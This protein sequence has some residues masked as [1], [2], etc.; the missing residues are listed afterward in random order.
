M[1]KLS[2][3]KA[4]RQYRS[5]PAAFFNGR[6]HLNSA[7]ESDLIHPDWSKYWTKY[8]YNLVE[9]GIL[10]ILHEQKKAERKLSVLDVGVGTGHWIE[11]YSSLF[12]IERMVG[13]DFCQPP[14][15]K[16]KEKKLDR[17]ISLLSWDISAKVP[18]RLQSMQFD[19]VNAIGV[20]FHIVDDAKWE[21]AIKNLFSLLKPEGILIVGGDFGNETKERGVMRKSRSLEMWLDLLNQ[22]NGKV[23]AVKRYNWWAGADNNG[24]TDNLLAIQK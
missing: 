7:N 9:N 1:E 6:I 22:L 21:N 18:K 14:L 12:Y 2:R 8:H 23:V 24:I 5:N 11:F 3:E 13:V 19:V 4:Y 17:K 10:E 15:E 16:L 20:I